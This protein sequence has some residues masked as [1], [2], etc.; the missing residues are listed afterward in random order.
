MLAVTFSTILSF[1]TMSTIL[2]FYSVLDCRDRTIPNQVIV[3]G[4]CAGLLIVTFSGHL[5]QYMEL[6][7]ISGVFMLTI[8]Y[9]L[10]RVGAF[11][12]ADM[13]TA[14]T[15][16]LVS[17]GLEFTSWGDPIIEAVLIAGLQLAFMMCGGY[18]YSKIKGVERERRVVPLIPF[19]L[20]A[21]LIL[22]LFALF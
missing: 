13:K 2:I 21:Y 18:L 6:H 16:S 4:L 19:L 20:G 10:F 12:G 7:L 15:I 14:L 3:L 1:A 8:G 5:L 22:Q 9:I 17:P 11:G